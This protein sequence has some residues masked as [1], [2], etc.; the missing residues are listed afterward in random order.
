[1]TDRC[2]IP[3]CREDADVIYMLHG[4]CTRH[5]NEL[6]NENAPP[7]ALRM[8]L[9]IPEKATTH[10]KETPKSKSKKGTAA[11]TKNGTA[12]KEP[13]EKKVREKKAPR[14]KI[15]RT[16][17]RTVALRVSPEDFDRIHAGAKKAGENLT[18][19]MF[20]NIIAAC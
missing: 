9:G 17:Y 16:G 18:A 20:R 12:A 10:E 19:F 5:W 11:K 14:E 6:T 1:M 4:V 3:R 2:E 15:D 13:E 7:G 8:A